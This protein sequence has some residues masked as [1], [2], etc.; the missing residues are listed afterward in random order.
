MHVTLRNYLEI[1]FDQSE[2]TPNPL[3]GALLTLELSPLQGVGGF[4]KH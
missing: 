2:T 3:K 1:I 4:L